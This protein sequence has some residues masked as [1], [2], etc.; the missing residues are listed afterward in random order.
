MCGGAPARAVGV[1]ALLLCLL[2]GAARAG[3]GPLRV[4]V[5]GVQGPLRQNVLGY[6]EI[7]AYHDKPAPSPARLRY[8]HRAARKQIEKALQPFGYYH[9][10]IE[11]ELLTRDDGW[12]A[13]YRIEPG[14]PV[15][16]A[17]ATLRLTGPGRNDPVLRGVLDEY[18]P[19]VGAPLDQPRYEQ[20]KKQLKLKAT[21][22]GYFDAEL[23]EHRITV[24]LRDDTARIALHFDT[25][26]RYRLGTVRFAQSRPW[27][28]DDFL[29]RYVRFR[30]GEPYDAGLLQALQSDL[31]NAN[32][33]SRVELIADPKKADAAHVI[34]VEVRLVPRKPRRY[35]VGVGYGTDTGARLKLGVTGRRV[36]R[37]G[38]HYSV[39]AI[40][41]Q[42]RTGIAGEYVIPG[43]DPRQ[44]AWGLRASYL[45]EHSD[46]RNFE[47][48][49]VGGYYKVR[50]G[51]WV[52]TYAL[53]HTIERFE[54]A[55]ENATST[56]LVPSVDWTRTEP[57]ALEKRIYAQRGRWLQ[58]R[59][60][61]AARAL[62][63][64]T[65]FLQP[66]VA[67]K[68]IHGFGPRVGRVIAR[69]A[70]GT[71][72]VSDFD[73]LPTSLRFFTGGDRTV[74][75]Y[76]YN[77]IGPTGADGSVVG[78]RHLVEASLEYEYPLNDKWSLA[79][80]VDS[81]DA[82]N[83]RLDLKTGVGLG[84]HWRSPIG[85]V[86]IDFGHGLQQ[87]VGTTLLLHLNIG[88]DL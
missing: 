85:P 80:F 69:G 6:L 13:R 73:A 77:V 83:D 28:D 8:L 66:L 57:G 26:P 70:L 50:H 84:L 33:F 39:E 71:T 52:K 81:G 61:G 30:P 37:R 64:D 4:E 78:G 21:E 36:N 15:R 56:M 58:L 74:R 47:S 59:L 9:P 41:A 65:D 22:R 3:A 12:L 67:A 18:A 87:P 34:P 29:R 60:R 16:V 17:A 86:R 45:D 2:A 44:D 5:S 75:G 48:V 23:R 20:L 53:D 55:G 24:D 46:T 1:V 19:R 79:A 40:L 82:F 76:A 38:H 7:W 35:V 49:S 72:W 51:L 62:L 88:P 27:L 11:A 31:F 63:S 54:V 32:Y 43:R 10:R 25:G 42:V 14:K 68:W